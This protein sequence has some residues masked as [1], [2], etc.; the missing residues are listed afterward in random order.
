MCSADTGRSWSFQF[1]FG[2]NQVI[3][4]LRVEGGFYVA[5]ERGIQYVQLAPGG[6]R[7]NLTFPLRASR[8]AIGFTTGGQTVI[9]VSDGLFLYRSVDGGARFD[10]LQVSISRVEVAPGAPT[11]LYGQRSFRMAGQS[12]LARSQDG[13]VTWID[14]GAGFEPGLIFALTADPQFPSIVYIA[15]EKEVYR[16]E[17]S[18]ETWRLLDR[19]LTNGSVQTLQ[20]DSAGNLWAGAT[21]AARGFVMKL[22]LAKPEIEFSTCISGSGGAAGLLTAA[23]ED[24]RIFVVGG[25]NSSDFPVTAENKAVGNSYHQMFAAVFDSSS[26][27]LESSRLLGRAGSAAAL[28]PL[29]RLHVVGSAAPADV[30]ELDLPFN[31][32]FQSGQTDGLWTTIDLDVGR[33]LQATWI[34]GAGT[35]NLTAIAIGTDQKVRLVGTTTSSNFPVT[36]KAIQS[37]T[38]GRVDSF[39]T[40]LPLP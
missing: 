25:T 14:I 3:A 17:D 19:G 11:I 36:P 38:G 29:G 15:S 4:D 5:T 9:W 35:D 22:N 12:L 30:A 23:R 1:F 18:G 39:L 21:L 40:V 2:A 33:I 13:G 20:F 26:G 37:Q 24:G 31:G 34:G 8:M 27:Q 6:S 28:D 16:S 10:P 32:S 7:Q